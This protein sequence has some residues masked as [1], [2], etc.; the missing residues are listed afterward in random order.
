MKRQIV[1]KSRQTGV[2]YKQKIYNQKSRIVVT[3]AQF[4]QLM[5]KLQ[6]IQ[7]DAPQSNTVNNMINTIIYRLHSIIEKQHIGNSNNSLIDDVSDLR[8]LFAS[9]LSK[10]RED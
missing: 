9:W 1:I 8:N 7:N 5:A 4:S 10:T 3:G 2:T 6:T